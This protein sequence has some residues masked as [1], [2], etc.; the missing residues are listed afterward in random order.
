MTGSKIGNVLYPVGNINDALTFYTQGLD[1][2]VKFTDGERYAALDGG[3]V[4]LALAGPEEDLTDGVAAASFKV[5]DIDAA[6]ERVTALGAR[7]VR[8]PESGP[9]EV[10]AV[11]RDPAGNLF[12][13]YAKGDSRGAI[14][15]R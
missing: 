6:I 2:T 10:R 14:P 5:A 7:L 15:I 4:T 11:L 9:H 8:G 12:I 1:L 3:G 13:L